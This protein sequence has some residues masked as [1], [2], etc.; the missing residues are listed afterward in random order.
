MYAAENPGEKNVVCWQNVLHTFPSY[1]CYGL[2][3]APKFTDCFAALLKEPAKASEAD[4][5][6]IQQGDVDGLIAF[7]RDGLPPGNLVMGYEWDDTMTASFQQL[8]P[9]VLALLVRLQYRDCWEKLGSPGDDDWSCFGAADDARTRWRKE[10]PVLACLDMLANAAGAGCLKVSKDEAGAMAK[11]AILDNIYGVDNCFETMDLIIYSGH[12]DAIDGVTEVI[13]WLKENCWSG[14]GGLVQLCIGVLTHHDHV[15]TNHHC[16]YDDVVYLAQKPGL[17]R[18][19]W[20]TEDD[21][22][23]VCKLLVG[24]LTDFRHKNDT[25]VSKLTRVEEK[26]S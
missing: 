12:R 3:P 25:Y 1:Q 22:R 26:K 14:Q 8:R 2:G 15:S 7:A 21:A 23:A 9:S 20:A 13:A 11:L 10:S 17:G 19:V 24:V 5:A 18:A 4:A 6:L 16:V